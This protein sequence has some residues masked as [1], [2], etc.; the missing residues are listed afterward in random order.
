MD[1]QRAYRNSPVLPAHKRYIAL[2]WRGGY[3]IDHVLRFGLATAGG[4]Q[5]TVADAIADILETHGVHWLIKWVDDYN[6]LREPSGQ[7]PGDKNV[8]VYI[9]SF[10]LDT[11]LVIT[12]PLGVPWHD[13]IIKGGIFSFLSDYVG[14]LWDLLA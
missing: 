2:H 6:F 14:F 8:T 7:R 9:H 11:I 3:Y 5:G 4:I 13:I 12:V 10:D 1:I